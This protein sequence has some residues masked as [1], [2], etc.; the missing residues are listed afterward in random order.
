MIASLGAR[1]IGMLVGLLARSWRLE[2]SGETHVVQARSEG[3]AVVFAVW[4]AYML[5]PLWHRRGQGVTLLVSGHRDG[6]YLAQAALK[7][8]YRVVRGSS[9]KGGASGLR[10]IMRV[11]SSGGEVAFT[12]DGPRGPAQMAKPGAV[13]AAA[14]SG[15]AIVPIGAGA[16]SCWRLRSWDRFA[17]PRPFARV[18]LVYGPPFRPNGVPPR[19]I[20]SHADRLTE[21]LDRA[22]RSAEC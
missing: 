4:H 16:S 14:Q 6:G 9:T 21:L 3:R 5:V 18:R 19:E 15:T 10:G 17:V 7:W 12:P 20:G 11:L 1:A 8:G 22:Q 2:V 13:A